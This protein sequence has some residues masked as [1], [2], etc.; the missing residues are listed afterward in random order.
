MTAYFM[1]WIPYSIW[2]VVHGR[3]CYKPKSE[4]TVCYHWN[5]EGGGLKTMGYDEKNP[6]ALLPII[7][8]MGF[9]AISSF[10]FIS[11]SYVFI[12][13][14]YVHTLWCCAV[15]SSCA[16]RGALRY[17]SMMTRYYERKVAALL[18]LKN[19]KKEKKE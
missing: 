19:E 17:Y 7:K 14:F 2:L 1:W 9:H 10:V 4:Q 13:N 18:E 5:A 15:F 12:W 8:Y 3:Y 16:W 6:E 11:F